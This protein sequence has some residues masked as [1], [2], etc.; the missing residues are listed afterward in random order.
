MKVVELKNTISEI[1]KLT[2]G[3]ND[4]IESSEERISEHENK[5]IEILQSEQQKE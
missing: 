1:L 5:S 3:L 2:D 4:G